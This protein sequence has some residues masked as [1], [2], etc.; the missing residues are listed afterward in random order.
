MVN[1]C[2]TFSIYPLF[3]RL[4]SKE[5]KQPLPLN[6]EEFSRWLSGFIDAEGNF[7]VFVDRN[8]LRVL[9]RISLHIDDVQ[10][11]H[12]IHSF[13]GVDTVAVYKDYCV[14]K[15]SSVTDIVKVLIPL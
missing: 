5:V 13:L 15:I 12:T 10:I 1:E 3:S 11:L 14:Y 2:I 7:Q 4:A 6:R 9:F 8:Y